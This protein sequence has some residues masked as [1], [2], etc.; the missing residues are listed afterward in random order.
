MTPIAVFVPAGAAHPVDYSQT[1]K[2]DTSALQPVLIGFLS[3]FLCE[4]YPDE[5]VSLQRD[6]AGFGVDEPL[7]YHVQRLACAEGHSAIGLR[8][9]ITV[10]TI[11]RARAIR[12][13]VP[14]LDISGPFRVP[15]GPQAPNDAP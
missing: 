7:G 15:D 4:D 9:G 14:I 5:L 6:L 10:S 3:E 2:P 8:V 12:S 13:F 11:E 1:L